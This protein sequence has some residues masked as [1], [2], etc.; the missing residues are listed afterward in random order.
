MREEKLSVEQQIIFVAPLPSRTR[1]QMPTLLSF[2]QIK[3]K[4]HDSLAVADKKDQ[5]LSDESVEYKAL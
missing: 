3:K 5:P 1:I 4:I 2:D